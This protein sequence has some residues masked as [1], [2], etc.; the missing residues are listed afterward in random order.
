[1]KCDEWTQQTYR[2]GQG[3]EPFL[4]NSFQAILFFFQVISKQR[5]TKQIVNS[6]HW[7]VKCKDLV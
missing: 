6:K 1:M 7:S 3:E 5:E 2:K 4:S